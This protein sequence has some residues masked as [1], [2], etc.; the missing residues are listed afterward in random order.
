MKLDIKMIESKSYN[1]TRHYFD[2]IGK[3]KKINKI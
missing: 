1:R 2:L 3:Y